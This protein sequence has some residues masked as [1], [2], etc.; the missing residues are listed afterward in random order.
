M[1]SMQMDEDK[2]Q[3]ARW[4]Q[5]SAG[6]L[7]LLTQRTKE[8]KLL[9]NSIAAP[10]VNRARA[11]SPIHTVTTT[12]SHHQIKLRNHHRYH[13]RR[14]IFCTDESCEWSGCGVEIWPDHL[15]YSSAQAQPGMLVIFWNFRWNESVCLVGPKSTISH[16]ISPHFAKM[17]K[18]TLPSVWAWQLS[19][20]MFAPDPPGHSVWPDCW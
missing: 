8:K 12:W 4:K 16:A 20:W 7:Y 5:I 17:Q 3:S 13:H 18:R 10:A 9:A 6:T 15:M 14:C 1:S 19:P 2:W 11:D